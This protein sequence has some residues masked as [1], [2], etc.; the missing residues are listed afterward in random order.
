MLFCTYFLCNVLLIQSF[1]PIFM[2]QFSVFVSQKYYCFLHLKSINKHRAN[3]VFPKCN[4]N[5]VNSPNSGYLK[6]NEA[7]I[8]LNLKILSPICVLLV[9][10]KHLDLLHKRWQVQALLMTNI[11]VAEFSEFGENIKKNSMPW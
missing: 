9:L 5:S 4:R 2:G 3:G 1:C 11:F 10:W 8:G 7:W 6:I